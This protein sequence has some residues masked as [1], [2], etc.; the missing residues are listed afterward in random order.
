VDRREK[1]MERLRAL[2]QREVHAAAAHLESMAR[3]LL[4]AETELK[5]STDHVRRVSEE[6]RDLSLHSCSAA[7]YVEMDAW[8]DTLARRQLSLVRQVR[9]ARVALER[10]RG[11]VGQLRVQE[12]QAERLVRRLEERRMQQAQVQERRLDDEVA[13]IANQLK[14]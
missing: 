7:D 9:E 13:R 8:L 6:R 14:E 5:S 2:R 10:Q 3:S 4:A 11:L 1:R 12:K